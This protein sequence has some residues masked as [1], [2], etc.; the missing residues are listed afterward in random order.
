MKRPRS[1][2]RISS[3]FRQRCRLWPLRSDC[4]PKGNFHIRSHSGPVAREIVMTELG[5]SVT[6]FARSESRDR[7]EDNLALWR[8]DR[9]ASSPWKQV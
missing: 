8:G 4:E 6:Q 1:V 3:T 9:E 2:V 5:R 7:W